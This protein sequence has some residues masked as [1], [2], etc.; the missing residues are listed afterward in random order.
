VSVKQQQSKVL[1]SHIGRALSGVICFCRTRLFCGNAEM[2][3]TFFGKRYFSLLLIYHWACGSQCAARV[4]L[5][6]ICEVQFC[7]KLIGHTEMDANKYV[8]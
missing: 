8:W 1:P 6:L 7:E 4:L 2:R 3:Q 5:G